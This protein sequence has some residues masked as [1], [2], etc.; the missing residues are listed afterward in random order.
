MLG[1][2]RYDELD[3]GAHA[4]VEEGA[5]EVVRCARLNASHDAGAIRL[6]SRGRTPERPADKTCVRR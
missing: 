4:A 5:R 1:R 2:R 3:R 6:K